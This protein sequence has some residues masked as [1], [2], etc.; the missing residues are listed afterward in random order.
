M[1]LMVLRAGDRLPLGA[2]ALMVSPQGVNMAMVKAELKIKRDERYGV[3][4]DEL[5]KQRAELAEAAPAPMNAYADYWMQTGKGFAIDVQQ[6]EIK[7]TAP[8]P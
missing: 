6:T 7:S 3:S 4:S 2:P 8:F 1:N 5:G